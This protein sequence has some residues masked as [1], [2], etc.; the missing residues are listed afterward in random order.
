MRWLLATFFKLKIQD[1]KV[2]GDSIWWKSR[3]VDVFG[4]K[5]IKNLIKLRKSNKKLIFKYTI[6][7][8]QLDI[9]FVN[10]SKIRKNIKK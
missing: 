10:L 6:S 5:D 8:M 1:V 3:E 4:G 2:S 7:M 9:D